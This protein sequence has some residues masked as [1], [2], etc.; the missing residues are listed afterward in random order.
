MAPHR[1]GDLSS[2]R[3]RCSPP[4]KGRRARPPQRPPVRRRT[5]SRPRTSG[6]T[7]PSCSRRRKHPSRTWTRVRPTAGRA[8]PQ[9]REQARQTPDCAAAGVFVALRTR[10]PGRTPRLPRTD[11]PGRPTGTSSGRRRAGSSPAHRRARPSTCS[12]DAAA[13]PGRSRRTP[14]AAPPEGSA[15]VRPNRPSRNE[16]TGS[17]ARL[18]LCGSSHSFVSRPPAGAGRPRQRRPRP[19]RRTAHRCG[20]HPTAEVRRSPAP[21]LRNRCPSGRL[22]GAPRQPPSARADPQRGRSGRHPRRHDVDLPGR[23]PLLP[24]GL[25]RAADGGVDDGGPVPEPASG[26]VGIPARSPHS[27]HSP[28]RPP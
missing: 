22:R 6:R 15:P 26:S 19:A 25:H 7:R 4:R 3:P 14:P 13:G 11:L 17:R 16:H 2:T 18:P 28:G 21:G 20:E 5:P 9:P 12:P 8:R 23:Q 24:S 27:G 1:I 10:L